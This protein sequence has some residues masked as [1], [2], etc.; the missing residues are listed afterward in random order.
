MERQLAIF[1]VMNR[2]PFLMLFLASLCM[3]GLSSCVPFTGQHFRH[4]GREGQCILLG[5]RED[6][7][8][9]LY[10]V[11]G[12]IYVKGT[13]TTFHEYN[14]K[15]SDSID[16]PASAY[17]RTT[18]GAPRQTVFKELELVRV[19]MPEEIKEAF[20]HSD[21]YREY[22]RIADSPPRTGLPDGAEPYFSRVELPVPLN[23]GIKD[24]E[25][26]R[27]AIITEQLSPN[28]H[29][30]Y[31]YPMAAVCYIG[32]D[33][34]IILVQ[35]AALITIVPVIECYNRIARWFE[36]EESQ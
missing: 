20:P 33:A 10:R 21:D 3:V 17:K 31:A 30:L 2:I 22:W 1:P 29:A 6:E 5:T 12:K 9:E 26:F 11:E 7:P 8:L 23:P 16:R 13:L 14:P 35:G 25:G 28:L 18:E 19:H 36:S 15:W 4:L 34:P 27:R 24:N 32:I